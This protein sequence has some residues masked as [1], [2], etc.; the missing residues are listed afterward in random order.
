MSRMFMPEYSDLIKRVAQVGAF[1]GIVIGTVIC[2]SALGQNL[3]LAFE[4]ILS[5]ILTI[6]TSLVSLGVTYCF[7]A[8]VQAQIETRNA[9]VKHFNLKESDISAVFSR[10][11]KTKKSNSDCT[12]ADQINIDNIKLY[13]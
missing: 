8:L 2:V 13:D 3:S 5:G 12:I 7:L 1:I 6:I 9:I 10:S 11:P 4:K